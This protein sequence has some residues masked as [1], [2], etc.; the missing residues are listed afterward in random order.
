MIERVTSQKEL[1]KA[2]LTLKP[3]YREAVL[4]TCG[5]KEINCIIECIFNVLK[6]KVPLKDKDKCKLK[7]HKNILRKLI[8]K[9]KNKLRKRIIIQKGGAFLPIIL[10]AV[11]SSII[12]SIVRSN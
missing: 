4:K 9:G 5:V 3:K 10:G 7:K 2:L 6:G 11:L 8:S 1:L 12:N